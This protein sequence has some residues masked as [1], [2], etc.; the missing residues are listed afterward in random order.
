MT[1]LASV[2]ITEI[3]Y[4]PEGSDSGYEWI[5]VW[6]SS[7]DSVDL[8]AYKL[9]ENDVN[10]GIK[11]VRGDEELDPGEYAVIADNSN[12]FMA[13][14]PNYSG[15]VFDSAFSL[16][17]SGELLEIIDPVGSTVFEVTY[18]SDTGGNGNGYNI[19]LIEDVWHEVEVSPGEVNQKVTVY[20]IDNTDDQEEETPVESTV[21]VPE[22]QSPATYVEI[23]NPDYS[24]KLIKVDAGGDRTV[25][26]GVAYWFEGTVYG[27]QGGV[28]DNPTVRWVWGDGSVGTGPKEMHTY[29]YPGVYTL[30]MSGR[31][32]KYSARDRVTVT[33]I[34]P[35]LSLSQELYGG[36]YIMVLKNSSVYTI[37]LSTYQIRSGDD[38]FI[39]P[40]DSF[41]NADQTM[42]LDPE[43]TGIVSEG[44]I[45]FEDSVGNTIDRYHP[46]EEI[47][48]LLIAEQEIRQENAALLSRDPDDL[49]ADGV[50]QTRTHSVA[51][52]ASPT[53]EDQEDLSVTVETVSVKGPVSETDATQSALIVQTDSPITWHWWAGAVIVLILVGL[54]VR[55][56]WQREKYNIGNIEIID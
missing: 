29:R 48:T 17:N 47:L 49:M 44:E 7:N 40:E 23:K 35:A 1:A 14:F 11:Q 37:E 9:R 16:N 46:G 31:T 36:E 41:I 25:M 26:A 19:G 4:N 52:V 38:I 3:H 55:E 15:L 42:Y 22:N 10:H 45:F 30:T 12:N 21:T 27:L 18:S 20:E 5:E 51:Y 8:T 39:F 24:E 32:G 34:P 50:E 13:A 28:L 43:V 33:V 6:N 54:Y 56:R 2:W 53:V